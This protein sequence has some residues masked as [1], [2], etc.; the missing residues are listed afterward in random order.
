MNFSRLAY[1][2]AGATYALAGVTI[3]NSGL[4]HPGAW[5]AFASFIAIVAIALDAN[6]Y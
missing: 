3:G 4:G 5:F 2:S 6:D 1:M